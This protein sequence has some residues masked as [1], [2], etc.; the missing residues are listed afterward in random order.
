MQPMT[1]RRQR[2]S[3]EGVDYGGGIA[4]DRLPRDHAGEDYGYS[5]VEDGADDERGNDADGDVALGVFA[6]FGGRGDGSRSRC[7]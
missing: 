6:L 3:L 1:S 5:D 2:H 7:R 4:G